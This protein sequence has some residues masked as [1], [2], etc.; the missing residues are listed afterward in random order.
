MP[1]YFRRRLLMAL[2]LSPL[3][4]ALP[5][6][7]AP[8]VDVQRIVALEWLPVELLMALGVTPM[9]VA[10]LFQYRLWVGSPLYHRQRWKSACAQNLTWNC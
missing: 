2:A 6:R 7:A 5:G 1:D 3:L 4:P 8:A 10:D 9:G